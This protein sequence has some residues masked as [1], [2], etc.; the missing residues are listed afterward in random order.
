MYA[1]GLR[2]GEATTLEIRSVDR[3]NQVLCCVSLVKATRSGWC[4]CP[5]RFSTS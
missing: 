4:C 5:S 1:C 2:I 3:A